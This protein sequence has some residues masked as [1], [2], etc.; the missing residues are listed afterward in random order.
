MFRDDNIAQD[1]VG[2]NEYNTT[3]SLI[4]RLV[5]LFNLKNNNVNRIQCILHVISTIVNSI[6]WSLTFQTYEKC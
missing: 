5:K 3:G 1:R 4:F 2:H 6:N